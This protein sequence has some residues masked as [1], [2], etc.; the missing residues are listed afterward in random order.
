VAL[1][2]G[3]ASGEQ[4]GNDPDQGGA[5]APAECDENGDCWDGNPATEDI[6][7]PDGKCAFL[8]NVKSD[9]EKDADEPG[10]ACQAV[11]VIDDY[12]EIEVV[13]DHV[14]VEAVH[15]V[16]VEYGVLYQIAVDAPARL[17]IALVD[18]W[19]EGVMFVLLRECANAC[20]N[21]IAWGSEICSPVLEPGDYVL[22]VFS[23][24]ASRF[25]F[26]A[27]LL[28]PE[29]SCDGLDAAIDC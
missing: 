10:F 12:S 11:G 26:T 16:P 6:C 5:L 27:D 8:S 18:P 4:F 28:P 21:R 15:T 13:I 29:E 2:A 7:A 3:C 14:V 1:C 17:E 22:A 24:R 25:S 20:K 9:P 19:L 23:E